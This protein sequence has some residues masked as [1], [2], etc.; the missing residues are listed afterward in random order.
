[1]NRATF[2]YRTISVSVLALATVLVSLSFCGMFAVV[3]TSTT[4]WQLWLG[5]LMLVEL[6]ALHV[7]WRSAR[8][9]V[10]RQARTFTVERTR[11]PWKPMS[12]TVPV[13][14]VEAVRGIDSSGRRGLRQYCVVVDLRT[15]ARRALL[16]SWGIDPT[17]H[18]AAVA[19]LRRLV[20]EAR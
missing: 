2:V 15:G 14:D 8:V 5:T 19:R 3:L 9:T 16:D 10:D 11:W 7:L 17:I 13:D 20:Q 4:A 6:L 18:A 1:M 12:W